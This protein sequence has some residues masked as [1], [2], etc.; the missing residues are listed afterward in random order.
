[1]GARAAAEGYQGGIGSPSWLQLN[2]QP[3]LFQGGASTASAAAPAPA[4]RAAP[5]APT[6]GAAPVAPTYTS[7]TMPQA[8]AAPTPAPP[9]APTATANPLSQAIQRRATPNMGALGAS[10]PLAPPWDPRRLGLP[11]PGS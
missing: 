6:L 2:R 8:R 7:A 9:P 5:T 11:G 10:D 3:N 1:M 4:A